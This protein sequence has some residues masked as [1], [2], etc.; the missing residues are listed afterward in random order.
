[1]LLMSPEQLPTDTATV[2]PIYATPDQ[3]TLARCADNHAQR[4]TRLTVQ[5]VYPLDDAPV[6][7]AD[8]ATGTLGKLVISTA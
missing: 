4:R 7:L 1:V 6:A 2:V 3:A 8:F 5:R